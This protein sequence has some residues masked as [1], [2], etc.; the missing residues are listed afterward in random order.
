MDQDILL[1]LRRIHG[2]FHEWTVKNKEKR[3]LRRAVQNAAKPVA[4]IIGTPDHRNIGDSAIAGVETVFLQKLGFYTIEITT[5]EYRC[6]PMLLSPGVVSNSLICFHGGGNMGNQWYR[7]E[8]FRQEITK[9]LRRNPVV[10][11][12]QTLYYT[13]DEEGLQKEQASVAVYNGRSRLTMVG[14]ERKTFDEMQRLYPDT[15]VMLVPDIVL[16]ADMDTFGVKPHVRSGVLLCMRSDVERSMTDEE[17]NMIERQLEQKG[18]SFRYTDMMADHPVTKENRMASVRE[19]ME[20]FSKARLVITDRM[21]G[22]VFAAITGTP[23]I[24]FSNYNH[25][26]CGTYEW[27][28]DL[29]Y[30]RF[31][32]SVSDVSEY[33][34]KLYGLENCRFNQHALK[35][36]Y[37]ELAEVV[38]GYVKS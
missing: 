38:K 36:Y 28:K 23:C 12:P 20:E 33:C 19:K 8:L 6:N 5:N 30:I 11:F 27:I 16:S 18:F 2:R 31:A 29:E 26:V 24:V 10:I 25:K 4:L 7:E 37:D 35:P 32:E 1:P 15:H 3:R 17:R 13:P 34:E 22:M 14:R 9:N 21:H